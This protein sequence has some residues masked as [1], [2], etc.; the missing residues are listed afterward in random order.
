MSMSKSQQRAGEILHGPEGTE[1]YR[2]LVRYARVVAR[3][4]G[5]R[6]G[7]TLPEGASPESI[8]HEVAARVLKGVRNW[9]EGKEPS[10]LNALKGMVRSEIGHLYHKLEK[11]L[12]E[13][14]NIL[15]AD[16]EERTPDSFP[17][18]KLHPN[19][20]SPEELVLANEQANLE[21]SAMN[22]V[23]KEVE[24]NDDLERVA[25]ALCEAES[26][27]EISASTG[28]P[29]K[30]VYSA[31]RELERIAKRIPLA[32]VIREAQEKKL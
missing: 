18:T 23:L 21:R 8:A 27:A 19:E 16:G 31:C 32:R 6:A 26:S 2:Q 7:A 14:I 20:P 15:S 24:G 17:S 30:R 13:P 25:L 4:H 1:I 10:L 5:W 22:L 28:L 3:L 29:P 12:V 11:G 9:D